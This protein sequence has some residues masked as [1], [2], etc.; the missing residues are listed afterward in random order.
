MS[1][2]NGG[3]KFSRV[4]RKVGGASFRTGRKS[5]RVLP[6]SYTNKTDCHDITEILLKVLKL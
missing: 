4:D 1:G 2:T 3:D 6:V 5:L